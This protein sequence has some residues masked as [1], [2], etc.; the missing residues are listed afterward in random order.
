MH[1]KE[2]KKWGGLNGGVRWVGRPGGVLGGW[3][4]WVGLVGKKLIFS[5]YFC[6]VKFYRLGFNF[7]GFIYSL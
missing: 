4:D 2:I 6:L 7:N 3:V 5:G 1:I